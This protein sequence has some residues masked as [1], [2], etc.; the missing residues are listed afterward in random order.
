ME[1]LLGGIGLRP[2]EVQRMTEGEKITAIKG[3][4][5]FHRATQ[6]TILE[7]GRLA[8]FLAVLPYAPKRVKKPSD[9]IRLWS[10]EVGSV[11][12]TK[13][14]EHSDRHKAWVVEQDKKDIESGRIKPGTQAYD[15]AI[16]RIEEYG[17]DDRDVTD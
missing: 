1:I 6:R 11:D 5:R 9:I 13:L 12:V 7:S 3:F 4:S 10:D 14:T 8:G 2:W 16:K 15:Q 17:D